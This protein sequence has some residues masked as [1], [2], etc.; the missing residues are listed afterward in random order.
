MLC[1]LL[2]AQG[3]TIA[4][5]K[6]TLAV[7]DSL[8]GAKVECVEFGSA[9]EAVSKFDAQTTPAATL[10][11]YRI[12]IYSGNHQLAR[13]EAE[14]AKL[15]AEGE[16]EYMR[17]LS[18]AYNDPDKAEFYNFVRSLDA[19]KISLKNQGNVLFLSKDSPLAQIF[20][21]TGAEETPVTDVP[22]EE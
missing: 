18:D 5:F 9:A 16:A 8:S 13:A 19:A 7:A 6:N 21:E 3:Q 22:G 15:E 2:G 11:G 1:A 4:Q 12:R 20:Y 10:Q 14:A 17:I